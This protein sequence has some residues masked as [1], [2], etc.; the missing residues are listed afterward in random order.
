MYSGHDTHSKN[1]V[2]M[3]ITNQVEKS[4]IGYKVVND[5]I[6]YIRVEAH[7]VNITCVQVYAPT[8][9][10]ESEDI[11]EFYRNLQSV[12]NEIPRKDVLILMEDWN[13][14]IGKGEETE[15]VGKYGL[16]NRNEEGG[17]LLE[18]CG[19]NALFLANT[20]FEQ[21]EWRLYTWTSPDGKYNNKI[22]YILGRR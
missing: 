11:E 9:S 22:N 4:L 6:M 20:Y 14:K 13:S 8:T 1:G 21:P 10:V 3:I 17:R 12:L 5:R 16:E 18:F 15:T 19:E 2:G 7:P